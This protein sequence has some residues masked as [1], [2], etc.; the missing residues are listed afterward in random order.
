[1]S[2]LEKESRPVTKSGSSEFVPF[3]QTERDCALLK[4]FHVDAP[5]VRIPLQSARKLA[6]VLPPPSTQ[7]IDA[8]LDGLHKLEDRIPQY[9]EYVKGFT[10]YDRIASAEFQNSPEPSAVRQF[11][12]AVLDACAVL[13]P[14]W[15]TV[16][17]LPMT[18]DARRNKINREL[19][20]A[21][22]AWEVG[23]RFHFV[24]PVIFTNQ[25]QTANKTIR[26]PQV[27]LIKQCFELAGARVVWVV[28]SN[29]VDQDGSRTLEKR[30]PSLIALHE[31]LAA[32][33][34]DQT[35][36]I[37]GPYWGLNVL[38]WAKGLIKYPGIT[39]GNRYRYHIAGGR[40]QTPNVR[41]ALDSLKRLI[42]AKPDLA[43]WFSDALKKTP[44]GDPANTEFATLT[45]SLTS[46]LRGDNRDQICRVYRRWLDTLASVPLPGRSLALYQQLS[47]AYVLGRSL[48]ELPEDG[49]ARR[50]ER[51][52]QQ[53]MPFCL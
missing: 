49:T 11:V 36:I 29:I 53:L 8:E 1:M 50:P 40:A 5:L 2:L 30:F 34:P 3:V 47:S 38:L 15:I 52:A 7:W 17:Q 13:K 39:L 10:G 24:L 32:I 51:V 21:S 14:T 41:V 44:A 9:K 27:R 12:T 33:L 46:M 4:S 35:P 31:E 20:K 28:D 42:V 6:A 45:T 26:N 37:G 16:P 19:A 23:K 18:G 22:A 43:N 25:N 48:P